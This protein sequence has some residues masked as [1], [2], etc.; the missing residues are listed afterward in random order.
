[1]STNN[2]TPNAVDPFSRFM[3][4]AFDEKEAISVPTGFQA[5]FG[6]PAGGGRTLFNPN[7]LVVDIDIIRGN[8]K[9][10]ALIPRG[11]IS[12]PL[13]SAQKNMNV[14]NFTSFSRKYP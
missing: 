1:M 8:K 2:V 5:F 14:E 13:G 3:A 4:D 11:M 6:N 9:T 12:R 10:A 7:S